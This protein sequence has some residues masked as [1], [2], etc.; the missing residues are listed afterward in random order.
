MTTR[1]HRRVSRARR[2]RISRDTLTL[3]DAAGYD[4][5]FAFKYSPRPNTTARDMPDADSRGR[6]VDGGSRF[7]QERQRQIQIAR[8]EKLVGETFE[9][10]VDGRSRVARPVGRTHHQQP[11]HKFHFAASKSFGTIRSSE[12]DARRRRTVWWASSFC[13]SHFAGEATMELEV[14]I[15]GLM[16]DP[17]TNMPVVVLKETQGSGILPSG[18]ASTKRTPSPSKSKKSR[19]PAP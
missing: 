10:L 8:N 18:W 17:V 14:K 19:R 7:L 4:G 5:V 13:R 11:H 1:H 12:S 16:M 15:R 6:K 3:L 9:V 2:K